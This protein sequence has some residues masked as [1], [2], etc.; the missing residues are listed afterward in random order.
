MPI[1]GQALS[2]VHF[3]QCNSEACAHKNKLSISGI[4]VIDN[5]F[6]SMHVPLYI[7]L[8]TFYHYGKIS[9]K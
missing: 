3:Q 2:C 9:R 4:L 5:G 8:K 7:F 1:H 6:I